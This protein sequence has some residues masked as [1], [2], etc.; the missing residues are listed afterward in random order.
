MLYYEYAQSDG[1]LSKKAEILSLYFDVVI[2]T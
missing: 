2:F 1:F